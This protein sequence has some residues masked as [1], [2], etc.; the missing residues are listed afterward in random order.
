[1]DF[2]L[3]PGEKASLTGPSGSGKSTLLAL[4]AGLLEPDS[5]TVEVGGESLASRSEYQRAEV[6]AR[7]TG[8]ALQSDN[9]IPFLSA[10]ENVELA[11][12]FGSDVT[13]RRAPTVA[14]ELLERFGVGHRADHVPRHLSGGEAQ[15]VALAVAIANRPAV[16]LADEVVA[17][18]DAETAARV[19]DEVL[20]VDIA[21]LYITHDVALADRVTT[22]YELVD[23]RVRPR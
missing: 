15:R 3:Q 5:G 20:T 1:M 4:I 23:H 22:R 14:R 17:Q 9:L 19:I 7:T 18:L 13:R 10:R 21:V 6:R 12:G 11:L 8:I 16:L 2:T